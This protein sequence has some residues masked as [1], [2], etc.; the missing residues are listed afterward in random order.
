MGA[1]RCEKRRFLRERLRPP[2]VC[3]S[4]S[5][6]NFLAGFDD[7]ATWPVFANEGQRSS[8]HGIKQAHSRRAFPS[9]G[10]LRPR[11]ALSKLL[12][13]S[14]AYGAAAG[15]L[16]GYEVGSV[17]L[18][19]DQATPCDLASI[20]DSF[21]SQRLLNFEREMMIDEEERGLLYEDRRPSIVVIMIRLSRIWPRGATLW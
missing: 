3:E 21:E 10:K 13:T 20:L 19:T 5:A 8:L 2:E 6:L 15:T 12:R 7:P 4:V 14:T 17:S 16:S 9:G 18:P 1:T 11:A